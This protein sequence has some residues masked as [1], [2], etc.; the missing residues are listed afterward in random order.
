MNLVVDKLGYVIDVTSVV[1]NKPSNDILDLSVVLEK[2]PLEP[3]LEFFE[4]EEVQLTLVEYFAKTYNDL[5]LVA[6]EGVISDDVVTTLIDKEI[7]KVYFAYKPEDEISQ[8]EIERFYKNT[9]LDLVDETLTLEK[10]VSSLDEFNKSVYLSDVTQ[11]KPTTDT[12]RILNVTDVL[13]QVLGVISGNPLES[14]S[15]PVGSSELTLEDS[16]NLALAELGASPEPVKPKKEEKK[17]KPK[18]TEKMAKPEKAEPK[19]EEPK[20]VEEKPVNVEEDKTPKPYEAPKTLQYKD[21]PPGNKM[22]NNPIEKPSGDILVYT[23][24]IRGEVVL[25]VPEEEVL[26]VMAEGKKS[27][28]MIKIDISTLTQ[29]LGELNG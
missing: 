1:L 12:P 9:G 4:N 17:P 20:K 25:M 14:E 23:N 10:Y 27:A 26:T 24:H 18:K 13:P 29:I 28:I 19:K 3:A 11:T 6:K 2:I 8:E 5:T 22:G 7:C 16:I 21:D 15:E